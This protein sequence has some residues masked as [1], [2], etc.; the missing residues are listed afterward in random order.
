MLTLEVVVTGI[1][2][3]TRWT[4]DDSMLFLFDSQGSVVASDDDSGEGAASLIDTEQ[5]EAGTYY[6][7]VTTYPNS[8]VL[9]AHARLDRFSDDGGSDIE[10]DLRVDFR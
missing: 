2:E 4:D 5:L 6:A 9:D 1:N 3:G 7:V 8:P 10:F